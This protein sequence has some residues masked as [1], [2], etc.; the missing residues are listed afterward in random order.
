MAALTTLPGAFN[1]YQ[2]SAYGPLEEQAG[3]E[4]GVPPQVLA[5]VRTRGER[6]NANQVSEVGARSVYQIT[7]ETRRLIIKQYGFDP[8]SSP[9]NAARGAAIVLR[10]MKRT[11]G[12]WNGAM[13]G[14]HGGNDPKNHGRR[15][16]A[17]AQRTRF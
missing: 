13:V 15:T 2:S 17:Y 4:F 7:P 1:S 11:F 12:D 6:S 3:R 8:W 9:Q 16:R 14:Y 5:R 10:D